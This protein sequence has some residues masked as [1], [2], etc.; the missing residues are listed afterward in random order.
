MSFLRDG[1]EVAQIL[2]LECHIKMICV[3]LFS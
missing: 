1:N 2:Q 3:F